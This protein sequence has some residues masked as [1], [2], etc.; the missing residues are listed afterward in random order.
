VRTLC[1][2]CRVAGAPSDGER[3]LLDELGLPPTQPVWRASGCGQCNHS[4]FS[5]RTGI[6]ELLRIDATLSRLIHDG[7]GEIAL[8]DAASR[9]GMQRL[10]RDG[11]R[12]IADGTTS[13]AELTRVT[14][15]Q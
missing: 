2:Q 1:T 11:A 3:R 14:R 8:R 9:A 15:E 6:Y 7:A 13:L 4:G 12:W 10:R 5:G